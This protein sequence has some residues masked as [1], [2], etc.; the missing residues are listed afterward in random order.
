MAWITVSLWGMNPS[1]AGLVRLLTSR[2]I[3]GLQSE[4]V[5]PH[6]ADG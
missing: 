3:E 6:I 1:T 2:N 5:V 4:I